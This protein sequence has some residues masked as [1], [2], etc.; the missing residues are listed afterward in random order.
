MREDPTATFTRM[1]ISRNYGDLYAAQ[2]TDQWV[3]IGNLRPAA[4]KVRAIVNPNGFIDE[5]DPSNNTLT[6]TRTIPGTIAT[7]RSIAIVANKAKTFQVS[8]KVVAPDIPGRNGLAVGAPGCSDIRTDIGCY[9]F[10]TANGPLPRDLPAAG[11]RH[12]LAGV[13]ERAQG[14]AQVHA[15]R[16]LHR[17][18]HAAVHGEPTPCFLT[19]LP[20]TVTLNVS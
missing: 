17:H 16:G 9:V 10:T 1:G 8:G 3:D 6:V 19:S 5:S 18:R 12:R 14:L 11:A 13:V 20:A 7:A 2:S 4:Y 15:E